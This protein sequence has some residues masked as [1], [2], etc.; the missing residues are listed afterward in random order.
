MIIQVLDDFGYLLE[1]IHIPAIELEDVTMSINDLK[2][3][4]VKKG[5]TNDL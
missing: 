2:W 4:T 3:K 5:D 1:T